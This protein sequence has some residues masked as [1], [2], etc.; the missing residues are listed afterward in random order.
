MLHDVIRDLI[1][2]ND[3]DE[4][5]S[6][7]EWEGMEG[8]RFIFICFGIIFGRAERKRKKKGYKFVDS[9]NT[10][11]NKLCM[12]TTRLHELLTSHI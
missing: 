12:A 4:E 1:E 3:E 11:S 8:G 9:C 2:E 7:V 10:G 6:R 5:G